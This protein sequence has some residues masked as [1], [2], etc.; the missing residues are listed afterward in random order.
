MATGTRMGAELILA[1][2]VLLLLPE[3]GAFMLNGQVLN[4][5]RYHCENKGRASPDGGVKMSKK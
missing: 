1:Q 5:C 4:K 3:Y 2:K